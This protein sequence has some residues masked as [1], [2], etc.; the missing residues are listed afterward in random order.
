MG[1]VADLDP[2]DLAVVIPTRDRPSMLS[3]TVEAL[4]R[5]TATGF[6]TVV[7]VDG[8]D[9]DVPDLP[10][11]RVVVRDQ[12]GPGA[13]RNTGS[14]A[15]DRHLVLFLGDDMVPDAGLVERHLDT[16]RRN[17]EAHVAVLGEIRTHPEVPRDRIMRWLE[18]SDSQF[19]F[20]GI[21]GDE[22]GYGRFYSSNLSL[23]RGFFLDAGGFDEDFLFDYEDLDCGRRLHDRGMR[24]L[25]EPAA[26]ARH[27][28]HYDWAAVERRYHSR[29]LGER[30]MAT[31]HPWF[32]PYF[33]AR[34]RDA[35]AHPR[36]SALWPAIA[37]HV[38][39]AA[40]ALRSA[41]R[42]RADRWYHRRL[43]PV[44]LNA[45]EAERELEELRAY[46]GGRYDHGRLVHHREEVE[47]EEAAA[48]DE[49][50]FYRTSEAYLYDLTAF[51]MSGTK[52]H[53]L[54]DLR[55]HVPIG[56]SVLD[57]G[58]GIG[59][60]GLRLLDAGYRAAF[61]DFDNPSTRYLRWRLR[62]R[63]ADAPVFDLD[64]E[65]PGGFDAAFSFDVIEHVDDP[66]AFLDELERR[67][68]IVVVNFLDADP[69]DPH[70]HRPLPVRRLLDHA[71]R[72]GLLR[73]RIYHGRS[74]LV[75]Y[76]SSARGAAG[77]LGVGDRAR[78]HLQRQLGVARRRATSPR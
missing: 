66:F 62:E 33:L 41:V 3:R 48:P 54:A 57:Y 56:S 77:R 5:Q 55:R 60:D 61:A 59:S 22:A 37:D 23:K 69:D 44:F 32:T 50:A 11:A 67:A 28:H 51:A 42:R 64:A 78:S 74:H 14:R 9:Q 75:V 38:P 21:A 71:T 39:A 18:W 2:R 34:I 58:C 30:L 6:E 10:G 63:G 26:V 68:A 29:A 12:G 52:F 19:A 43:A 17:P 45:W 15:T 47:R 1:I 31:K 36:I 70:V 40:G 46:L 72:R 16:H 20:T 65:V 49:A 24:L 73:Y 53:Y 13:A 27:L 4:A 25:Y 8:T 76:R 7:V 35:E